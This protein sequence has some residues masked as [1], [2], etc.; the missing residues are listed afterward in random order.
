MILYIISFLLILS[1]YL[2]S[3]TISEVVDSG[4]EFLRFKVWYIPVAIFII[5]LPILNIVI[6]MLWT[7]AYFVF[8]F[9]SINYGEVKIKES[10]KKGFWNKKI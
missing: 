2:A 7:M 5:L 10:F 1:T 3:R 8:L 4:L 6:S 9:L